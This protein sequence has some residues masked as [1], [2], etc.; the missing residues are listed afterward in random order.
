[1][2]RFR[3]NVRLKSDPWAKGTKC[4]FFFYF[5]VHIIQFRGFKSTLLLKLKSFKLSHRERSLVTFKIRVG[6]GVQND[7]PP[8]HLVKNHQKLLDVIYGRSNMINT[9]T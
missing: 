4:S 9:G 8:P 3:S 7:P 1:M 6:R 5:T 2:N